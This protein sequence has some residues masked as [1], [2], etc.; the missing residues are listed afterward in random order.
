VLETRV[1]SE[2][3]VAEC[4][5]DDI[6]AALAAGTLD[7]GLRASVL[8]HV[9]ECAR[10]RAAVASVAR[11][12]ADPTV[13][14]EIAVA[15]GARR[16]LYRIALPL[17][18]AAV[19]L[20]LTWPPPV[21]NGGPGHRAPPIAAPTPVPLAPIGAV[22]E[23]D[24]LRWSGVAGADRYRVTLFDAGGRVVYEARLPDT[25]AALPDSIALAPGRTYLWKVEARTGF[26]RWAASEL[27]EF[28]IAGT[29]PR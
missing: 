22:A 7:P 16:R 27:V 5:D 12:L 1:Q 6:I 17:A 28:S 10:C 24:V 8:L 25:L 3:P 11:A 19:L 20:L 4:V 23:A 29:R 26:D 18:A 13:A 15:E 9:A 14:R 21:D 2:T